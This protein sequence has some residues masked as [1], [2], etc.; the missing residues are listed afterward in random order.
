ME[1]ASGSGWGR[2]GARRTGTAKLPSTGVIRLD[3]RGLGQG[4]AGVGGG[5]PSGTQR[6]GLPWTSASECPVA[7]GGAL[8]EGTSTNALRHDSGA[9]PL[10]APARANSA[11]EIE[12]SPQLY[13]LVCLGK[14]TGTCRHPSARASPL[15]AEMRSRTS[16]ILRSLAA[17]PFRDGDPGSLACS[18]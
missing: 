18:T 17:G 8:R 1:R 11:P 16:G 7:K 2:V 13:P 3:E 10:L 4:G 6:S 9:I 5:R 12:K 15:I 14:N